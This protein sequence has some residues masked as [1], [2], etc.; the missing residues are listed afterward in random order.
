MGSATPYGK[1]PLETWD[2]TTSS[3]PDVLTDKTPDTIFAARYR[4]EIQALE[5]VLISYLDA[6]EKLNAYGP[7]D[8]VLGVKADGTELEYKVL[9]DGPGIIIT[10]TPT[11]ITITA[12]VGTVTM[13]NDNAG[14]I[15]I[16]QAVYT[17]NNGNVD[18]AQAD[19]AG[20]VE[21]LG[22]VRDTSIATGT[23]GEIQTDGTLTATTGEWDNVTGET[24]GLTPGAVY[25]LDPNTPGSLTQTAPTTTGD[26]VIRVGKAIATTTMAISISQPIL[27]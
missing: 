23:S 2:G 25:Y 3:A 20:T 19:A 22:L 27:L 7:G 16:G 1:F 6:L 9:V 24:G 5:T 14:T 8:S 12:E 15:V 11:G 13:Q 10:H 26:F 21:V 18:L 17:K 4:A